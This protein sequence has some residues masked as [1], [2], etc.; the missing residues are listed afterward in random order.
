[1]HWLA[2]VIWCSVTPN[3]GTLG[4]GMFKYLKKNKLFWLGLIATAAGLFVTWHVSDE[5]LKEI[6]FANDGRIVVGTVESKRVDSEE[7]DNTRQ[8]YFIVAYLFDP[9]TISAQKGENDIAEA[10]YET[11]NPG[12]AIE[13]EYVV[14]DPTQHRI[15]GSASGWVASAVMGPFSAMFLAIGLSMIGAAVARAKRQSRLWNSGAPHQARIVEFL[16]V[17]PE[18]KEDQLHQIVY[19]Y[20]GPD[21]ATHK[22]TSQP[23]PRSWF[24]RFGEGEEI[25]IVVDQE[26]PKTSEWRKEMEG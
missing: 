26:N 22:G 17:N 21:G 20:V 6:R 9:L 18:A 15:A 8:D 12:D 11:F 4:L 3:T 7:S 16:C 24:G 14:R 23:H 1:M 13:I 10:L 19:E 2:L 5:I 25:D